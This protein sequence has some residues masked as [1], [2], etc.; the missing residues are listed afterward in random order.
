MSDI[1]PPAPD[2]E[3]VLFVCGVTPVS[4]LGTGQ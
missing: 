4:P 3:P 2:D 1:L